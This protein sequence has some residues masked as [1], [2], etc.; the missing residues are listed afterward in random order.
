MPSQLPTIRQWRSRLSMAWRNRRCLRELAK[1]Y[2][3][4]PLEPASLGAMRRFFARGHAGTAASHRPADHEGQPLPWYTY[5]F[6]DFVS[7]WN[8]AS[9]E[10][11]E[12]GSGQSTLYWAARA[13]RVIAFE[14]KAAWLAEMSAK[15]PANVEL[16]AFPD[17]ATL[18]RL[19]GLSIKPDLVIIDG[20]QR[21]ACAIKSLEAFGTQPLYVLDNA[22][23]FPQTAAILR[24]AGMREMRFKGFGPVNNYAWA[25]SLL[26]SPENLHLLGCIADPCPVPGGL[27]AGEKVEQ[28]NGKD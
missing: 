13:A 16:Q 15:V 14:N 4:D 23:W 26:V 27:P 22:D 3:H 24:R 6:L 25:T 8:T 17:T 18:D 2:L 21:E 7:D 5:P 11:L 20:F 12:F 1:I 9:W 19:P 28:L 10:I